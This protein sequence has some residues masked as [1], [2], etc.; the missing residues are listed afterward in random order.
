MTGCSKVSP[1]CLNCYAERM[2]LRLHA[3]GQPNYANGF[4]PSLHTNMLNAPYDAKMIGD[5]TG[6]TKPPTTTG[7]SMGGGGYVPPY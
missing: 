3:M 7:S 2:A 4:R 1:G 6:L 5:Y